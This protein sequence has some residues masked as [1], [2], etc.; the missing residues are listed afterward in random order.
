MMSVS[1]ES[2]PALEADPSIIIAKEPDGSIRGLFFQEEA[3]PPFQDVRVRRALLMAVDRHEIVEAFLEGTAVPI[4]T[5]IPFTSWGYDPNVAT[6]PHDPEAAKEL[7]EE[8]GWTDTDGDGI[9]DKDG[10]K[11]AWTITSPDHRYMSDVEICEAAAHAWGAVGCKVSIEVLEWGAFLDK[12]VR[13]PVKT[14]HMMFIGSLN[15]SLDPILYMRHAYSPDRG[16]PWHGYF[17]ATVDALFEKAKRE[18]NQD[19][20]AGLYYAIS[21]I[22][23]EEAMWVPM[24]NALGM[25]AHRVALKEFEYSPFQYNDYTKCYFE[26]G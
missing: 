26:G 12:T 25:G 10:Q 4:D 6:W 24:F 8:A 23:Y 20:R 2:L 9:R 19:I 14:H 16:L 15:I 1:S 18:H 13:A 11:L 7:L 21:Q 22:L 3:F 17:N 5:M